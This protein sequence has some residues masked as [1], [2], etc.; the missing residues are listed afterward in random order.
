MGCSLLAVA[1]TLC[2][3]L[4]AV[5][6]E[7]SFFTA[8]PPLGEHK[9]LE[10]EVDLETAP[11]Q[12]YASALKD[13]LRRH[14]V[15][16]FL[17]TYSGWQL[18]LQLALPDIFGGKQRLA[19]QARWWSAL[20]SFHAA[21]AEELR[22]L[23]AQLQAA[24]GLE[25]N[26]SSL[27]SPEALASSIAIYPLLNI[28]P[29]PSTDAGPP[30]LRACTSSL[31]KL[32]SGQVIHGRSLDYEPRD[33]MAA[34]AVIVTHKL[35]G[36]AQ[37]K[38]LQPLVYTTAFQWF[39]CVRPKAFSLSVNA[40][41]RGIFM[42]SN[43]TFD[44]LL[45][46]V[47][48]SEAHFLGEIAEKAM[49]S[50]TYE[51]ALSVLASAP[52]VSSNYFVLAGAAGQGAIVTRF[53]NSSSA[54]VWSIGS[55]VSTSDGQPPWLRVQTNVDH[56]VP[57]GEAYAT[58]RRQHMLN[59]LTGQH[60]D[61]PPATVEEF[62]RAYFSSN[63]M[64]GS[65]N[66]TTPEDTGAILRPTTIATI[67]MDPSQASVNLEDWHVWNESAKLLPPVRAS[68]ASFVELEVQV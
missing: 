47:S 12:R 42:E 32:A 21:A 28:A 31:L 38:C 60:M 58:H 18:G 24:E 27:F 17:E 56:W 34:S 22:G 26:G 51:E 13:F 64:R 48:S 5:L 29:R 59:M 6:A 40:R 25:G 23:S 66:R 61:A 35:K 43:A 19:S 16:A 4:A 49:R 52:V 45:R 63:K 15:G 54:D 62:K 1:L 8:S 30:G 55:S 20:E 10:Y 65:E 39:T 68:Q 46:R 41:S 57:F 36:E 50:A 11:A 67:F 9:L 3:C 7:G 14:G 37:Y 53:G 33:P 2:Q 44:E